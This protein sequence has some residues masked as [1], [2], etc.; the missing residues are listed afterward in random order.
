MEKINKMIMK[1]P[2]ISDTHKKFISTILKERKGK[3]LEKALEL[4]ENIEKSKKNS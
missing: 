3:I 2:Y 4:N 1:I